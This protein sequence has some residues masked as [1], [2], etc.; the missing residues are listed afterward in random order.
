MKRFKHLKNAISFAQRSKDYLWVFDNE[1]SDGYVVVGA[2]MANDLMD[3]GLRPVWSPFDLI[4][5]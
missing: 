1:D 5:K 4:R 3:A 2:S